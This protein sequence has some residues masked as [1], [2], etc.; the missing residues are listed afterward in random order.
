[1]AKKEISF[2]PMYGFNAPASG[3]PNQPKLVR[4]GETA[5]T[6]SP[7]MT[8]ADKDELIRQ[9]RASL[10]ELKAKTAARVRRHRAKEKPK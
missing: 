6:R 4:V 3:V 1:M 10:A 9:L 8:E 7:T 2:R 5:V